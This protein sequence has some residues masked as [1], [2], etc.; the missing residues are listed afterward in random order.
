[1]LIPMDRRD[2]LAISPRLERTFGA[3]RADGAAKQSI[4]VAGITGRD[5]V[6]RFVVGNLMAALLALHPLRITT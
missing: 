4:V 5:P 3:G 6:D 1:M 2:E